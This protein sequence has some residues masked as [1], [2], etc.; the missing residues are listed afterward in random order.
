MARTWSDA[1]APTSLG[2][3]VTATDLNGGAVFSMPAPAKS[4][5]EIFVEAISTGALTAAES[6]MLRSITSSTTLTSMVQKEFVGAYALG[7]LGTFTVAN[8]PL[9]MAKPFNTKLPGATTPVLFQGQAQIANTVAPEMGIEMTLSE[10]PPLMEEQ[11]YIAPANETNTGTAAGQADG[12]DITINGGRMINMLGIV[13]TPGVV[14]ASE[15]HHGRMVLASAN[16]DNVASPQ[17]MYAQPIAVALGAAIGVL[18]MGDRWKKVEIPIKNTF[19]GT[20]AYLQDEAQTATG[21]Y[22]VQLGYLKRAV[23][24]AA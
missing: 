4:L 2:T 5:I 10:G 15:S 14:T 16:F 6:L 12:N 24:A 21:N 23:A 9:L 11:F 13:Q 3:G 19:L 8:H 22:I 20:T 17:R 7:G 1:I 18:N